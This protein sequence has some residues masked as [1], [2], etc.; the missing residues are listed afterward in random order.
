MMVGA[1]E[2]R[3][4]LL[5]ST[6]LATSALPLPG[7]NEKSVSWLL[8]RKPAATWREPK[9][10]SIDEVIEATLPSASTMTKWLVDGSSALMPG[11]RSSARSQ[12]G[13]P[14]STD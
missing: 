14:A 10:F 9:P 2:E 12:G 1:M 11:R 3:G 13:L 5:G 4:R 6:R 8:S 7:R